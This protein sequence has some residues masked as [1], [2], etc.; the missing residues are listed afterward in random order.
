MACTWALEQSRNYTFVGWAD[1][2]EATTPNIDAD[3]AYNTT[4][5]EFKVYAVIKDKNSNASGESSQQ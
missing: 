5:T 3:T 1:S 2:G 4:E